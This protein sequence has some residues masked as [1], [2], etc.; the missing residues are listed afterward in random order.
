[1]S[2]STRFDEIDEEIICFINKYSRYVDLIKKDEIIYEEYDLNFHDKIKYECCKKYD[3]SVI[4]KIL[5]L[6]KIDFLYY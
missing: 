5:N 1:M 6:I 3:K 2:H 4:I